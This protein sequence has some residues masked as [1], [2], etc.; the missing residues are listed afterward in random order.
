MRASMIVPTPTVSA[1]VGTNEMSPPKKR[2]FTAMVSGVRVLMRVRDWS[3]EKGSLKAMW[4]S[5]PTPPMKRS[6]PP[7]ATIA[8]S[9]ASHSALRSGALPLRICTFSGLMSMCEK[10]LV[11]MKEW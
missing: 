4:P 2:E 1:C 7:A 3:D 10:K 8:A 9:Y 6:M 5:S 11:H